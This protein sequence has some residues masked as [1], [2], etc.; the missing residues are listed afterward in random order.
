MGIWFSSPTCGNMVQFTYEQLVKTVS[1]VKFAKIAVI[2]Q[3]VSR[4]FAAKL[5]IDKSCEPI[6]IMGR[7]DD[8]SVL[9]IK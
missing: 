6:H 2:Q 7:R 4:K 8:A 1:E 5:F 9:Y 3:K